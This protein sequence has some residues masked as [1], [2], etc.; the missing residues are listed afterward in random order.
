MQ[1]IK[2]IYFNIWFRGAI[3]VQKNSAMKSRDVLKITAK[4]RANVLQNIN[5]QVQTSAIAAQS[6]Q[7]VK[8]VG[9]LFVLGFWIWLCMGQSA[10]L[11]RASIASSVIILGALFF[12]E[13]QSQ[14]S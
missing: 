4:S 7:W 3:F 1:S 12:Y 13:A 14:H 9:V 5:N 6:R 8:L 2:N 11:F 10:Y